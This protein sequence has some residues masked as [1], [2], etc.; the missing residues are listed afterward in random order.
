[1]KKDGVL[2]PELSYLIARC[3]HT[4]GIVLADQGYPVPEDTERINLGFADDEPT[5][6]RVLHQIAQEMVID[7]IIITKEMED[8]SPVRAQ[9]LREMFPDILFETVS[10]AALKELTHDAKGTV[11][12]GDTTPYANVMIISG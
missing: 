11:K 6:I 1:M 10:H 7:R 8:I 3:G 5:V 4:D 2:H 9:S 12:T